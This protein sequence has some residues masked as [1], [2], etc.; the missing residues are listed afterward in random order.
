MLIIKK[1]WKRQKRNSGRA[2]HMDIATKQWL[3]RE[4]DKQIEAERKRFEKI[5]QLVEKIKVREAEKI[6]AAVEE[7]LWSS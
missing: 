1:Q 3:E 2:S 6:I 5:S 4:R 7:V